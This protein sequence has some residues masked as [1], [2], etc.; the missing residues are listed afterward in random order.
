MGIGVAAIVGADITTSYCGGSDKHVHDVVADV[1]RG[2]DGE[3]VASKGSSGD[4]CI[5]V[6][7]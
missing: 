6:V 3:E 4:E 5:G 1:S 2:G 7:V